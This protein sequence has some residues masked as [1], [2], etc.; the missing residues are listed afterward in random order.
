[1]TDDNQST[2]GSTAFDANAGEIIYHLDLESEAEEIIEE[3][4]G[5]SPSE[6]CTMCGSR[7]VWFS[8]EL[9]NGTST[10][11]GDEQITRYWC[12]ECVPEAFVGLWKTRPRTPDEQLESYSPPPTK[13]DDAR[14]SGLRSQQNTHPVVCHLDLERD[15]SDVSGVLDHYDITRNA[16]TCCDCEAQADWYH[17]EIYDVFRVYDFDASRANSLLCDDC[18]EQGLVEMWCRWPW[19]PS[20]EVED[21][22]ETTDPD[23][24]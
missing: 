11:P 17:A 10:D 7:A 15:S 20:E 6:P 23:T 14:D 21:Q 12:D 16:A 4:D 8:S 24:E 5:A 22:S 9:K 18:I 19:T 13:G 1:M 3:F 2:D